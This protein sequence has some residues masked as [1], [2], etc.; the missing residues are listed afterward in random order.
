MAKK[1]KPKLEDEVIFIHTDHK[2]HTGKIN[3]ISANKK[4]IGC[5]PNTVGE[6]D[7]IVDIE[8]IKEVIK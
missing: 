6:F 5:Y 7:L 3:F 2:Q 8:N 1:Y 4:F